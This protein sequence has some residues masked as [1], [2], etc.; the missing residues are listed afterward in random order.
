MRDNGNTLVS[1]MCNMVQQSLYVGYGNFLLCKEG[2]KYS[3]DESQGSGRGVI[4]VMVQQSLH[5]FFIRRVKYIAGMKSKGVIMFGNWHTQV[6]CV[7][8]CIAEV[9]T[10]LP[11]K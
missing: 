4:C 5:F 2:A 6:Q 1:V 7:L 10:F 3:R 9:F 11:C 8:L